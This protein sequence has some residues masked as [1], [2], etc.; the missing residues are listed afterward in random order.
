MAR[1]CAALWAYIH[2]S[3]EPVADATGSKYA[4]L[5]HEMDHPIKHRTETISLANRFAERTDGTYKTIAATQV[6]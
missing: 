3:I 6:C 4:G 5:R 2:C 1:T